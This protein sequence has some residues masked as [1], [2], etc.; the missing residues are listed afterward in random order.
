MWFVGILQRI[1]GRPDSATRSSDVEASPSDSATSGVVHFDA[2]PDLVQMAGTM[3]GG[4]VAMLALVRRLDPQDS[5][6][7]ECAGVLQRE[8][9]NPVDPD[10]VAVHVEGE[11]VG[12]V[13]GYVAKSM[14]LPIAAAREVAVQIFTELL[15]KGLRIE[16]WAWLAAGA[17][18][19]AWSEHNRPPMS[20]PAKRLAAHRQADQMVTEALAGRGE[21]AQHFKAG[22]VGGVHY[23]QTVEPIKQLKREGRLEEALTLCYLAIDG[24]EQ[25]ARREHQSP[26]PFYTEQAAI[27]HRKLEQRD[28]E[29]AV[30][31]R[32]VDAC[33]PQ[34]RESALKARLD[35]LLAQ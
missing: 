8:P 27:V 32:Y 25:A 35:K 4:R 13:P 28:E 10:A 18:R 23:L 34:Y 5:G 21:R 14:D 26:A 24:A 17:P 11:R 3:T 22:M 31:R 1:F 6:Y 15:E 19:W 16:G 7:I 9:S 29:I 30:L 20:A 2:V 12:Y 33:P